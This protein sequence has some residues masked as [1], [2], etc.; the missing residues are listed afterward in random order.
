MLL[1]GIEGDDELARDGLVRLS[2]RQH[3]QHLQ[4]TAGQLLDQAR[5]RRG[6]RAGPGAR[7][8]VPDVKGALEPGQA[9][10]RDT[11]GRLAG[12]LGRDQ[13]GQ[14]RGHRR[15]LVGEDPDIA[16]RAGQREH[17]SEGV[18]RV[19]VL[20]AGGQRQ[21]PQRAGLDHAA[22][23]VL[24]DRRGVQP[25]QQRE[26]LGGPLLGQQHPGQHQVSRLPRVTRLIVGVQAGLMRPPR[27]RGHVTLGQQQPGV[28]RR[29]RVEQA[30]RRRRGM[31][32]F[33]DRLQRSGGIAGGL[34]YPRQRHQARGQRCPVEELAA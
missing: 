5:H 14:Q 17:V 33:A 16:L 4:L 30:S 27:G 23:P 9:A 8:R 28:L 22:D 25:V 31:L 13:P 12:P 24:G 15:A 1:D 10:E 2:C 26:R 11:R 6:G 3:P 21:R 32:G 20:A 18:H 19:G 34:S 29:G 7:P